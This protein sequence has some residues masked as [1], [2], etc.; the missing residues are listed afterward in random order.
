MFTVSPGR[1]TRTITAGEGEGEAKKKNENE[2]VAND[3]LL[4]MYTVTTLISR[5]IIIIQCDSSLE[6]NKN[7]NRKTIIN[8]G[9]L[10]RRLSVRVCIPGTCRG[11]RRSFQTHPTETIPWAIRTMVRLSNRSSVLLFLK[12]FSYLKRLC[13]LFTARHKCHG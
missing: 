9:T 4:N 6:K 2:F 11:Y 13:A 3:F 10:D 8:D 12:F 1:E 7:K 5:D